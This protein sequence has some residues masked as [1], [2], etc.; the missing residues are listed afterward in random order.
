MQR[1]IIID[2]GLIPTARVKH[3]TLLDV[4]LDQE[5]I[6]VREHMAGEYV[7]GQAVKTECRKRF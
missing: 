3:Q 1:K 4:L 7:L 2:G 6:E 5:L